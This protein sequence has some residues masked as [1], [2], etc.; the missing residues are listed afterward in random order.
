M[1]SYAIKPIFYPKHWKVEKERK[2]NYRI[3]SF[4]N[5]FFSDTGG[6]EIFGFQAVNGIK[7]QK[8]VD[9]EWGVLLF[10]RKRILRYFY[11]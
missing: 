2:K 1:S 3:W 7:K 4:D 6:F 10:W 5:Y 11:D 8:V 9:F